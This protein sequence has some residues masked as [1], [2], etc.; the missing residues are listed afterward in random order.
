MAMNPSVD[1]EMARHHLELAN[2]HVA[3]GEHRIEWQVALVAKLER[4]GHDTAQAKALL[5][6][7][8]D[9]LALQVRTRA[10][11]RQELGED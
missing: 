3:E 5:K 10:R 6:Q 2:R 8:E 7:F 4:D 11:L 9:T 1:R